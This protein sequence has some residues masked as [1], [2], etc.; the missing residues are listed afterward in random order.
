M[1]YDITNYTSY[2]D[3]KEYWINKIK[4]FCSEEASKFVFINK[5][6]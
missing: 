2:N 5:L 1:V 3:I 4:Q 6:L